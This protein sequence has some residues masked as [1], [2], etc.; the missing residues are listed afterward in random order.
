MSNDFAQGSRHSRLRRKINNPEDSLGKTD[1]RAHP[2]VPKEMFCFIASTR[3]H[4]AWAKQ[5]GSRRDW[6]DGVERS[7]RYRVSLAGHWI[8]LY[9]PML[10]MN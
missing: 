1:K 7:P 6:N 9:R 8:R 2:P 4:A 3:L 10:I 5:T